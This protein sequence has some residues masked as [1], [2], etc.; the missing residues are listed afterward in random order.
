M[1]ALQ[2]K[3]LAVEKISDH[4]QRMPS[5]YGYL[6]HLFVENTVKELEEQQMIRSSHSPFGIATAIAFGIHLVALPT[7]VYFWTLS[8]QLVQRQLEMYLATLVQ[9]PLTFAPVM[10]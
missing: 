2:N 5:P 3:Y 1:N 9:I 10:P 7:R 4:V 6:L 8:S